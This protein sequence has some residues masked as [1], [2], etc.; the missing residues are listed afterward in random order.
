M[1]S[2]A[3]RRSTPSRTRCLSSASARRSSAALDGLR[4][5]DVLDARAGAFGVR[6]VALLDAN[7]VRHLGFATVA[8]VG[9]AER[10]FPPPPRQDALLLDHERAELNARWGWSLPLRAAGC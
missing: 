7:A 4:A 2:T 9:V 6:G 1:R 8:I 10:R 5:A 3:W